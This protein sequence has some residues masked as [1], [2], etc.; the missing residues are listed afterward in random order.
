MADQGSLTTG[1]LVIESKERAIE[2]K[3][4]PEF[5][6]GRTTYYPT[7]FAVHPKVQQRP[8]GKVITGSGPNC[9]WSIFLR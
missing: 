4:G 6:P 2:K 8:V 5:E 3:A 1:G 9:K 7:R